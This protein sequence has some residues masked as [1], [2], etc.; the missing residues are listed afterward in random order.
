MAPMWGSNPPLCQLP[1]PHVGQRNTES[2]T[3][4]SSSPH[5]PGWPPKHGR[6]HPEEHGASIWACSH[7]AGAVASRGLSHTS[8]QKTLPGAESTARSLFFAVVFHKVKNSKWK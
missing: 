7:T 4:V 1:S 2:P 5:C 8:D 6:G 3:R